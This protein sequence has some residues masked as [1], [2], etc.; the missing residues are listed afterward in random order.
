MDK[1][2]YYPYNYATITIFLLACIV[3]FFF[4]VKNKAWKQIIICPFLPC[5]AL[6]L[7]EFRRATT[8]AGMEKFTDYI[9][10]GG[11][12]LFFIGFGFAYWLLPTKRISIVI[13]R[14]FD[15]SRSEVISK[16]HLSVVFWIG[17]T[18]AWIH[19]IL[20]WFYGY[21]C[22]G[23]F[24][25]SVFMIYTK[26]IPV[27]LQ[28]SLIPSAIRLF[29]IITRESS[30]IITSVFFAYTLINKSLL[31]HR[32][33]R[34]VASITFLNI[35]CVAAL[36]G[37]R[38]LPVMVY[39]F[40]LFTLVILVIR[41]HRLKIRTYFYLILYGLLVL[42]MVVIIPHIRGGYGLR[43]WDTFGKR[44]EKGEIAK[45]IQGGI[46]S[47]LYRQHPSQPIPQVNDRMIIKKVN[48][49]DKQLNLPE[50]NNKVEQ[51]IDFKNKA[52]I[53]L[54][55]AW[56]KEIK[57]GEEE[58]LQQFKGNSISDWAAWTLAYYGRHAKFE[59]PL[60]SAYIILA[61]PIPRIFWAETKPIR[62]GTV[63]MA[64]RYKVSRHQLLGG[65]YAG[66]FISG[67]FSGGYVEGSILA[68]L[69][70][71]FAGTMAKLSVLFISY[72]SII[73]FCIGLWFYRLTILCGLGDPL[74]LVS[75]LYYISIF[76][77]FLY[78]FYYLLLYVL[79]VNRE[80]SRDTC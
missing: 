79:G 75:S 1:F 26:N 55:E 35:L 67:Y 71:I 12:I 58:Y 52:E 47:I 76:S 15:T 53:V 18:I 65:T 24:I 16:P 64:D 33:Y 44:I 54:V 34:I 6:T 37:T 29:F 32:I 63:A 70:G 45:I 36:Y 56:K 23:N 74:S 50:K 59:G 17:I 9:I 60:H 46:N 40:L 22:T 78:V 48:E 42:S 61:I 38:T 4:I 20:F 80:N 21:F 68:V 39:C 10:A 28:S 13:D 2:A 8:L 5:C 41:H 19:T 66:P 43:K 7:F 49:V 25:D 14:L 72:R 62:Y 27:S 57:E 11:Y 77:V 69:I 73:T 51:K 3:F 30:Y 31:D